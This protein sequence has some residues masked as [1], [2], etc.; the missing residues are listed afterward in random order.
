MSDSLNIKLWELQ[1]EHLPGGKVSKTQLFYHL[2]NAKS[3]T[4]EWVN[5][6]MHWETADGGTTWVG[7][8]DE[9]KDRVFRIRERFVPAWEGHLP[10]VDL[11]KYPEDPQSQ[12]KSPDDLDEYESNFNVRRAKFDGPRG[13]HFRYVDHVKRLAVA[14][15]FLYM[16]EVQ[17]M[18]ASDSLEGLRTLGA[19]RGMVAIEDAEREIEVAIKLVNSELEAL[20]ERGERE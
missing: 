14:S 15:E 16:A 3:R 1:V 10:P 11:D 6:P 18:H 4:K 8:S 13:A 7:C 12:S 5:G 20:E 2:E 17:L 19:L 9:C